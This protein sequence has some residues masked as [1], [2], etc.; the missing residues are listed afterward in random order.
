[1]FH[2][3]LVKIYKEQKLVLLLKSNHFN[4]GIIIVAKARKLELDK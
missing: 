2:F 3:Y 4:V 1:M